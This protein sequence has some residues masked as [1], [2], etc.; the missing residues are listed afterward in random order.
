M[1]RDP[2]AESR[3]F[4]RAQRSGQAA[5]EAGQM[6][7]IAEM[8][9][10]MEEIKATQAATMELLESSIQAHQETFELLRNAIGSVAKRAQQ[11]EH[12][13]SAKT[14]ETLS[15]S[16]VARIMREESGQ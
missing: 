13:I 9:R 15:R 12:M 2:K 8:R 6:A 3:E 5:A 11:N 4:S 1:T 7:D 16:A 14:I 10:A